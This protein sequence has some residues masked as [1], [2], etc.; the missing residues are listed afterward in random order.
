MRDVTANPGIDTAVGAAIVRRIPNVGL[1]VTDVEQ[2]L[3]F[4]RDLLGLRVVVDSGWLDDP[5][6]LA[7]TATP[8]GSIRIV[9]LAA[10]GDSGATITVVGV[11]GIPRR[12][13]TGGEFHDVGTMHLAVETAD[14]DSALDTL[15]D[16][17]VTT[18]ALPG[19]VSGGGP[20]HARVA[21]VRDPDGFFV[22]L[23][24]KLAG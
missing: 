1:H 20:G 3:A 21:F 2:S 7:L 24:Q 14:L 19:T 11:T 18:V 12:P 4:Y 17:G 16:A 22:E 8:G 15:K 9:N 10:E 6:L 23:V 13:A 5:D